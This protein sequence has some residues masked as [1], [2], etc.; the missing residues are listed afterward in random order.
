MRTIVLLSLAAALAPAGDARAETRYFYSGAACQPDRAADYT[1]STSSLSGLGNLDTNRFPL[2]LNATCPVTA[3]VGIDIGQIALEARV[4]DGNVATSVAGHWQI[5]DLNLNVIYQS[6]TKFSCAAANGCTSVTSFTGGST[7]RWSGTEL[8]PFLF[9]DQSHYSF[10]ARIPGR[11][12]DLTCGAVSRV[13]G[14]WVT[15][16]QP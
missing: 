11:C 2:D 14:Y 13:M 6:S 12:H 3:L 10:R 9:S 5:F 7:L 1:F 4:W 15:H 16:H 8:H